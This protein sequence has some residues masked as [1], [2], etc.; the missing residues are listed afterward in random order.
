[1]RE[2]TV[3][4]DEK[5]ALCRRARA[6]LERQSQYV[7]LSFVPAGSDLAELKFPQIDHEASR[8]EL[9]VIA[10]SG[11]IYVG[12]KSW[13]MCLWALREYRSKA[14]TMRAPAAWWAAKKFITSVSKNRHHFALR[15]DRV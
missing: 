6:W 4:Y 15:G 3:L 10:D 9:T 13:I 2:L 7:P 8:I 14:L 11:E 12:A 5:C 1:M